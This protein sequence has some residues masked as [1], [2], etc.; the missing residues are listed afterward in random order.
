MNI[1]F[2][3]DVDY[4]N[5]DEIC[6]YQMLLCKIFEKS[7]GFGK[8]A[9]S[10]NEI[11][12]VRREGITWLQNVEE[13]IKRILNSKGD[14]GRKL[15]AVPRLLTSYDFFYRVCHYSP[16]FAFVRDTTLKVVDRWAQG[17]KSISKAAIA[18]LLQKE[19]DRDIRSIPH[20]YID[21][22][23]RVLESW[24]NDLRLHGKLQNLSQAE[25]Y[26]V[27]GFLLR[28]DLFAFG[29]SRAERIKWIERYT[30]T[31][32]EIDRMDVETM[33]AYMD[34]DHK[35]AHIKGESDADQEERQVR[36]I[37]KIASHP[38]SDPFSRQAIALYL[39]CR[40]VA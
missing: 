13:T 16:C 21:L 38:D 4:S 29:V 36:F 19:I 37:T 15:G 17:N 24:I 27:I 40:E 39:A 11:A 2:A 35:A 6:G 33:W 32:D 8:G 34:F 28:S 3:K 18:L 14:E 9:A 31:A 12:M 22:S 5:V 7:G 20:R 25:S 1:P 30:L 23:M 10:S 26:S